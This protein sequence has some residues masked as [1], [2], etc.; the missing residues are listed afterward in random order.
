MSFI[1]SVL[2]AKSKPPSARIER[3]LLQLQQY[4]YTITHIPGKVNRADIISHTPVPDD[5]TTRYVMEDCMRTDNYVYSVNVEKASAKDETLHIV[6]ECIE[7]GDWKR[8]TGTIYM[9]VKDELWLIGQ[10]VMRGNRIILP[11]KLW[12]HAVKLAHE[13]H[14]GIV[15]TKSR[16]PEKVWWPNIDK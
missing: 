3:W 16:L 12:D 7:S 15:H 9:A 14:Q 10:I 5:A 1:S 2:G 6:Q 11:E 4:S 8:L 13:G